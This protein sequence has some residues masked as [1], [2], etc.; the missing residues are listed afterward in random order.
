MH[1]KV[2]LKN[3][4]LICFSHA[5]DEAFNTSTKTAH[6]LIK[7]APS[8]VD[9]YDIQEIIDSVGLKK[10]MAHPSHQKNLKNYFEDSYSGK[11]K[12]STIAL[13]VNDL[14]T[15]LQVR[16]KIVKQTINKIE[17]IQTELYNGEKT[18]LDSDLKAGKINQNEF[19]KRTNHLNEINQ[20]LNEY[21]KN[22]N[23][24]EI[25]NANIDANSSS[26]SIKNLYK[27]SSTPRTSNADILVAKGKKE[28][29]I[30]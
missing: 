2:V 22:T 29:M 5:C 6:K 23:Y 15:F 17:T 30:N 16:N 11:L 24:Q 9:D 19:N 26:Q 21:S 28:S 25:K 18:Q 7:D 20:N 8:F 10:M 27:S 4:D 3:N 14:D 12:K 13:E 1:L